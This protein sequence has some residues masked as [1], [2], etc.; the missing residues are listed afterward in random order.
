MQDKTKP[1]F[2]CRSFYLPVME[3][4]FPTFERNSRLLSEFSANKEAATHMYRYYKKN[5]QTMAYKHGAFD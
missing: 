2:D 5:L 3:M 1:W 4:T